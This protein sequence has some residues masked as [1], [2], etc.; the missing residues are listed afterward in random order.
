VGR[1]TFDS[2]SST[3]KNDTWAYLGASKV[4]HVTAATTKLLNW[5]MLNRTLSSHLSSHI[6]HL[7]SLVYLFLSS[8]L[9]LPPVGGRYLSSQEKLSPLEA[10]CH[11]AIIGFNL[12]L[13]PVSKSS[14]K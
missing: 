9:S 3:A 13:E 14:K 11:G 2:A 7:S 1:W 8:M 10:N 12:A 4:I 6:S 5:L